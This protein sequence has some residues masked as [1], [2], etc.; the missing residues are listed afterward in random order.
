MS[1]TKLNKAVVI[2]TVLLLATPLLITIVSAQEDQKYFFEI[3]VMTMRGREE[4]QKTFLVIEEEFKKI[5]IKLTQDVIDGTVWNDRGFKSALEGATS[6]TGGYDIHLGQYGVGGT[7]DPDS[8][9]MLHSDGRWPGGWNW[10]SF[11]NADVDAL[12]EAGRLVSDREERTEIY[13]QIQKITVDLVSPVIPLAYMKIARMMNADLEGFDPVIGTG[14]GTGEWSFEGET[15]GIF[16]YAATEDPVSL[17]PWW[18]NIGAG[19]YDTDIYETLVEYDENNILIPYLAKDWDVS[20]DMLTYTFYL[21][22]NVLWHDGVPFTAEDVVFT[23]EGLINEDSGTTQTGR[24]G[25]N[26]ASVELIDE[27]TVEFHLKDVNAG[28]FSICFVSYIIPKHLFEG[29]PLSEWKHTDMATKHPIG[30]GPYKFVSWTPEESVIL[31]KFEDYWK[32]GEPSFDQRVSIILPDKATALAA[33]IAGEVDYLVA[34][35]YTED[36]L[37]QARDSPNLK[38]VMELRTRPLMLGINLQHPI[39]NNIYVRKA[40]SAAVPREKLC[41]Q[42]LEGQAIPG[43]SLWNELYWQWDPNLR[44]PEYDIDQAKQ[45]MEMAGYDFELLE[46]DPTTPLS[47]SLIYAV[48]GLILGIVI[49]LAPR[50]LKR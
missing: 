45:Y 6:A 12:F 48:G 43:Y 3:N 7:R 37:D 44:V 36:Q 17:L 50:F 33:L 30:T 22:E 18:G 32:E 23:Y 21:E 35:G 39:L 34:T 38:F 4:S 8:F 29:V 46:P 9:D 47:E 2:I 19:T 10:W 49:G 31:D 16:R 28:A 15:G 27:Y 14:H 41:N 26:I 24:L 42:V 20:D 40:I 13:Q 1:Y 11:S 5:G 25:K